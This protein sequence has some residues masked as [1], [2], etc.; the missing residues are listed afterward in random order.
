VSLPEK[1]A[2]LAKQEFSFVVTDVKLTKAQVAQIG[3]AVAQAGA[4]ALA[5]VTPPNAVS[6]Q[7][8]PNRWWRGIP[9]PD[10][11]KQLQQFATKSAGA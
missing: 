10:L 9:A 8:G 11:Y 5:E 2:Q 3:Q 1:G 7:I 6:V 4:L